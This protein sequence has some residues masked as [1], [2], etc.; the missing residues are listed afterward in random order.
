MFGFGE[1]DAGGAFFLF[2]GLL[3]WCGVGDLGDGGAAGLLGGFAGDATPAFGSLERGL[4]EMLF[5]SAGEDGG[6]AGD[7]EF[8]GLFDGP[9]HVVE[10]EDG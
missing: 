9:L 1:E 4:G 8:G 7:A 10:L 2:Q 6:D 5:G 3:E